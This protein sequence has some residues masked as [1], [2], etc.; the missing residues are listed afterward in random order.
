MHGL[1]VST[2]WFQTGVHL[3]TFN[4]TL[5]IHISNLILNAFNSAFQSVLSETAR[6]LA[7]IF[8]CVHPWEELGC[9]C[10]AGGLL[11]CHHVC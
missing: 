5:N 11:G 1:G 7:R 8:F 4:D 9:G 2:F 10:V 3:I 6:S